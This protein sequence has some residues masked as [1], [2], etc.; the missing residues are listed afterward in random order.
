MREFIKPLNL[1]CASLTF[2]LR[3]TFFAHLT[4]ANLTSAESRVFLQSFMVPVVLDKFRESHSRATLCAVEGLII[5]CPSFIPTIHSILG[6]F[7]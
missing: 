1:V 4:T 2:L 7:F 3:F 6:N 5:V